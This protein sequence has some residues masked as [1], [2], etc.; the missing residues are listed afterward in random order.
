MLGFLLVYLIKSMRIQ[1]HVQ[2]WIGERKQTENK[3]KHKTKR[4][5]KSLT[6]LDSTVGSR[7]ARPSPFQMHVAHISSLVFLIIILLVS[8]MLA[9][10]LHM[11]DVINVSMTCGPQGKLLPFL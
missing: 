9:S 7:H 8:R 6:S 4:R 3:K 10:R 5:K 1:T 11:Y 2:I